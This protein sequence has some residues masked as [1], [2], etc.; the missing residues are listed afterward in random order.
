MSYANRARK[1]MRA[2]AKNTANSDNDLKPL[3]YFDLDGSVVIPFNCDLKYH[4]WS[5]GQVVSET[6]EE[7]K[8]WKH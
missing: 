8:Q 4:W 7:I 3:P 1:I 2:M 5:A 6:E